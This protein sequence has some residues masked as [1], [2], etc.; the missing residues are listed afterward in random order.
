M[1]LAPPPIRG[2]WRTDD[3]A[4]AAYAEAAGVHRIVPAGIAVPADADDL[5]ALIQWAAERG[6]PITARGSGSSMAGGALGAGV[7]ADL[8]RLRLIGSVDASAKTVLVGPGAICADVDAAARR[9]GLRFPVDPSSAR[10]CSVGGMAATNAAGGRTLRYGQMNAWVEGLE[11][12][13]AD[14]SR[15][16]VRRNAPLP[17]AAPLARFAGVAPALQAAERQRPSRRPGV[18]KESSGYALATWASS[19]SLVDLLVGSEGTLAM[20]TA[21]ELR[22]APLPAA[23]ATVIAAFD[24]LDGAAAA[25]AVAAEL[26]A[27][28]C[29][30]LDRTFLEIARLGGPLPVPEGAEAVLLVELEDS[31]PE[32]LKELTSAVA[33]AFRGAGASHVETAIDAARAAKLWHLRHAA[34]P[35]LAAMSRVTTSM[36]VIEDGAVPPANL[37]AYV[38]GL[39]AMLTTHAFGGVIFGHAGDGHVHCN[40][41]VDTS[42]SDWRPRLE[43]LFDDAVALIVSLGGTMTGEHGDGRLRAG[44]LTRTWSPEAVERFRAVKAAFDPAGVLNPGVKFAAAGAAALGGDIKYDTALGALPAGAR[45]ALDRVQQQRGWNQFRLDLIDNR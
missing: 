17:H 1:P 24:S 42:E 11:C 22:L 3:L 33:A 30:L 18:R 27:S 4:C 28:A 41:L 37:A 43:R 6:V 44:A 12:V 2:T 7:I 5:A 21:L 20:F 16:W 29:E 45:A 15:G 34:S 19:G 26:S 23:N 14:G 8:S 9:H 25:A 40:V 35:I 32:R 10:F 36:Q 31:S 13:F 38:R 39:R